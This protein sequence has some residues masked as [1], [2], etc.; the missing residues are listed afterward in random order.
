MRQKIV[1]SRACSSTKIKKSIFDN[2]PPPCQITDFELPPDILQIFGNRIKQLKTISSSNTQVQIEEFCARARPWQKRCSRTATSI[3]MKGNDT[4]TKDITLGSNRKQLAVNGSRARESRREAWRVRSSGTGAINSI[5]DHRL[6]QGL[7][8]A[9]RRLRFGRSRI[10]GWGV[11]TDE[12][13]LEGEAV[14]EYRGV[15]IGNMMADKRE[16][17]YRSENRDD[18]MFR[19]DDDCVVDATKRG[20]LARF[21]NHSCDPNCFTQITEYGSKNGTSKK[22]IIIYA[23]RNISAGEELNY[24]YKFS[25]ES[26]PEKRLPCFCGITKCRGFMN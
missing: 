22:K 14:L 23:K 9:G 26:D 5:W 10:E 12:D 16:R 21:V 15:L 19:M 17:E 1:K 3:R 24:D 2:L 20:S 7:A 8:T 18:Y 13:I 6:E 4:E 25:L 11:F